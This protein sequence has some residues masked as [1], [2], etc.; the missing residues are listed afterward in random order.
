MLDLWLP[1]AKYHYTS[2]Q[3]GIHILLKHKLGWETA[4]G[5]I[6]QVISPPAGKDYRPCIPS[7]APVEP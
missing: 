4:F 5:G 6:C 1:E 7:L 3:R 2:P